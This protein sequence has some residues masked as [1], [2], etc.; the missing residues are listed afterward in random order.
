MLGAD[1]MGKMRRAH[2]R[3]GR[4]IKG[5]GRDLDVSGATVRKACV[6]IDG[7]R[8]L[9]LTQTRR[10]IGNAERWLGKATDQVADARSAAAATLSRSSSVAT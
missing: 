1:E 8:F 10:L 7:V 3:E 6:G 9:S 5:I 4:S 2:F